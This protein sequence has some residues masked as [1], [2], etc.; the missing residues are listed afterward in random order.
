MDFTPEHITSLGEYEVFVFGSNLAGQHQGGAARVARERFGAIMGQ[1]VG[2]QGQSY[3]IPTMEGGV[4]T[5]RPYVDE[6]IDYAT[7]QTVKTFLVTKIGCGIAGF[8]VADIAPLF[9]RALGESQIVLPK[10]FVEELHK[11]K[12]SESYL[13][14]WSKRYTSYDMAIDCLLTLNRLYKYTFK[15]CEVA[16][17]GLRECLSSPIRRFTSPIISVLYKNYPGDKTVPTQENLAEYL[18]NAQEALK[19]CNP[20][21]PP[22][23]RYQIVLTKEVANLLL[24]IA[25]W[26]RPGRSFGFACPGDFYYTLFSL[27]SGRWNCGDNSYLDDDLRAAFPIMEEY[28]RNKWKDFIVNGVFN[29]AKAIDL[30]SQPELWQDWREKANH[31]K[32]IYNTI[33]RVLDYECW[34]KKGEYYLSEDD[35]YFYPRINLSRP[36]FST[37]TGRIHFPNFPL[38]KAF[39]S[40]LKPSKTF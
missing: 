31:K 34:D 35:K 11:A 6:F 5:I 4:E 37:E 20:L 19:D 32:A 2:L 27:M 17:K 14:D 9:A 1:G 36:V 10:E 7:C 15:D 22:Y 16:I 33:E 26:E 40:G 29:E 12:Y 23:I 13:P 24:E 30:L 38:K 21:D 25:N 8:K 18:A 28:I 3:A 39:I